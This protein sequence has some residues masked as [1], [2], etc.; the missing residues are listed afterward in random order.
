MRVVCDIEEVMLTNDSG[1]DIDGVE[2][3]CR[4]CGHVTESFGTDDP[5][6]KRCLA[7]MREECPRGQFN[8]YV[9]GSGNDVAEWF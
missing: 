5:S 2:A 8:F 1:Y 4:R 3:T 6:I 9:Q 7:L